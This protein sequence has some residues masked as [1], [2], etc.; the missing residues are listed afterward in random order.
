MSDDVTIVDCFV[1]FYFLVNFFSIYICQF[2]LLEA[3]AF[4]KREYSSSD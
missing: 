1:T 4:Q 3:F 2:E